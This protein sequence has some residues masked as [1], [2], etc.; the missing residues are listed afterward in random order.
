MKLRLLA[1]AVVAVGTALPVF[2]ESVIVTSHIDARANAGLR[3]PVKTCSEETDQSKFLV[4]SEYDRLG[5]LLRTTS[6]P[7]D[8][9]AADRSVTSYEYDQTGT[10]A[11]VAWP[12]GRSAV[13]F[14]RDD[15][16]RR[17]TSNPLVFYDVW[18][19][20]DLSLEASSTHSLLTVFDE[21]GLPIEGQVR[22]A[23]G[24]VVSRIVRSYDEKGRATGDRL[25]LVDTRSAVPAKMAEGLNP[26][27][28]KAVGAFHSENKSELKYD[29]TGRLV[30]RRQ[31]TVF[32]DAITTISYNDH[33]DISLERTAQQ[34]PADTGVTYG[35]TKDGKMVPLTEP[36]VPP[37][38]VYELRYEYKYDSHG[39]WTS[40][41]RYVSGE[42]VPNSEQRR[43]LTYF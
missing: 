33:G 16:G 37:P 40:K 23:D 34:Q 25:I 36:D 26:E 38:T 22:G 10:L 15:M 1:L 39:N 4:V 31:S 6:G 29:S 7:A 35:L 41:K 20:S 14:D 28:M 42:T 11:V 43:N 30:E 27:Q 5:R 21:R 2:A 12:A 17:I 19:G 32:G 3:G 24:G 8:A 9:A 18:H 13:D